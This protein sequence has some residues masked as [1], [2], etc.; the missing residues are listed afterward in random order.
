MSRKNSKEG[1]CNHVFFPS[2]VLLPNPKTSQTSNCI[3]V[4]IHIEMKKIYTYLFIASLFCSKATLAQFESAQDSVIQLYGVIMTAD[5][6]QGLSSA[7]VVIKNTGRGTM[8]NDK[9]VFS[10]AVLKGDIIEFTCVGFKAKTVTIPSV[11]QGDQYSIIQ[12]MVTDT[13]YLP[14]TIIK[15]RPTAAEFARDFVNLDVPD[16][17][18]ET[19]RKNTS[20]AQRR[21][22]MAY[23]PADGKE[24]Y[25]SQ[26]RSNAQ[27]NYYAGQQAP[28]NLLNPA[29]WA[30]FIKAWKRGDFKKKKG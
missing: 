20:E 19:A 7:S 9:G 15:A 11:M 22:L 3:R 25:N 13:A 4:L 30:D 23:L 14:A 24:A 29:A 16:D 6:L 17:N 18:Y 26:I 5:S 21:M 12:L 27:K 2:F 8:S 1:M 10:I 28:V